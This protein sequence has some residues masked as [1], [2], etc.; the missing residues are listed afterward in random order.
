LG[1]VVGGGTTMCLA[2]PR[3][4][5]G[6][7]LDVDVTDVDRALPALRQALRDA[8]SPRGTRVLNCET[9]E[10]LLLAPAAG[11]LRPPRRQ[12]RPPQ[13][14]WSEGEVLGYR[15][16]HEVLA[17]LFVLQAGPHP[18]FR[19]LDWSGPVV[20]PANVVRELLGRRERRYALGRRIY[21]VGWTPMSLRSAIR[22]PGRL[23]ERRIERPGLVIPVSRRSRRRRYCAFDSWPNF[24]RF[25]RLL[26]GL[27]PTTGTERLMNEVGVGSLAHHFAIWSAPGAVT[28]EQA[29]QMFA[30]YVRKDRDKPTVP[31]TAGLRQLVREFRAYYSRPGTE[32]QD[33][34]WT[35][36]FRAA[37]GFMIVPIKK[38]RPGSD[39]G[40][41]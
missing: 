4:V 19:V 7:Y 6:C 2:G 34:P 24:D 1:R 31:P 13:Y 33:H 22:L 36:K 29:F 17:L 15:L 41:S 20:P 11:T 28:A 5:T 26:F 16:A 32:E 37:E 35:G 39:Q 12:L 9:E 14:P 18:V 30:A 3:F 40:N 38:F 8:G 10:V 23:D 27:E 21:A 25:L